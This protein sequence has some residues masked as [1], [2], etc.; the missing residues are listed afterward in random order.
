M[1]LQ[2]LGG[3]ASI[4]SVLFPFIIPF[5]IFLSAKSVRG[6]LNNDPTMLMAA[7]SATPVISLVIGLLF[8]IWQILGQ[9]ITVLAL[10][11]RMQ[12]HAPLLT[13][14]MLIA[15]SAC[16]VTITMYSVISIVGN[17]MIA[18]TQDVSAYRALL[19]ITTGLLIT[20]GILSAWNCLFIGCAILKTQSLS[21]AL[22][23]LY[24]LTGMLWML[25]FMFSLIAIHFVFLG[26]AS[27]WTGIALLRQK[28]PQP[29]AKAMAAS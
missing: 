16:T 4:A 2:R 9:M 26:I 12:T 5:L 29:A 19:A 6:P 17:G 25:H 23:W 7:Y 13:R 15:A 21:R 11:E 1:K 14:L 18:P 8:I 10:H 24:L 20:V 3:Y 27:V 28:Q 22:G